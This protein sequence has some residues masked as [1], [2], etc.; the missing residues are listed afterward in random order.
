[1]LRHWPAP[2]DATLPKSSASLRQEKRAQTGQL[3]LVTKTSSIPLTVMHVREFSTA[4]RRLL[5][6]AALRQEHSVFNLEGRVALSVCAYQV[7]LEGPTLS[8]D[9]S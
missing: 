1:M 5:K 6:R 4:L 3:A 2:A 7:T 9:V 8:K